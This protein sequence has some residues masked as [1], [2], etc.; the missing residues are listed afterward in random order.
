[1]KSL[2]E[3]KYRR[4]WLEKNAPENVDEVKNSLCFLTEPLKEVNSNLSFVEFFF[5]FSGK[6][7]VKEIKTTEDANHSLRESN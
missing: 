2:I 3:M 5:E 7:F 4:E 1:M 6:N